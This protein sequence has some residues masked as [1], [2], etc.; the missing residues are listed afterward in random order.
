M[1]KIIAFAVVLMMVFALASCGNSALKDA[2]GKYEGVHAKLVG[3]EEW[4]EDEEPFSLD[5][6]AD[7]TAT[8]ARNGAE[9]NAT[10]ELDG[11]NFKMTE[12]FIGTIDYT[13][14]LEGTKLT[15][16][17]GDPTNPTTAVYVYEK[18]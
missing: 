13:G 4:D 3:S 8:S 1:K 5:L 2:A 9:Y 10:W 11:E 7:G 6:K 12:T 16:Y 18:Q 14:T 15:L 17:N